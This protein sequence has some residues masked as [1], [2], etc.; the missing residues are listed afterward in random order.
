[1]S[2]RQGM[3]A[4]LVS[5]ALLFALAGGMGWLVA[6]GLARGETTLAIPRASHRRP[7]SR[8][9]EPAMYWFLVSLYGAIGAGALVLGTLGLREARRLR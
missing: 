1:M 5:V 4:L 2:A 3:R 6:R 8:D 9:Q 7:V